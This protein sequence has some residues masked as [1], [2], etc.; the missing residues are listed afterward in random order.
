MIFFSLLALKDKNFAGYEKCLQKKCDRKGQD[1]CHKP[2]EIMNC[3]AGA[4]GKLAAA[5]NQYTCVFT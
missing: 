1:F 5:N 3:C 4:G 2:R